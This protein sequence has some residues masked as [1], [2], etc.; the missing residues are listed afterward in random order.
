MQNC[1]VDI[2]IFIIEKK[3]NFMISSK[4]RRVKYGSGGGGGG[5]VGGGGGGGGGSCPPET[6]FAPPRPSLPSL[7][8]ALGSNY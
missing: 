3:D 8:L 7:A 6:F 2:Y 4:H 1:I 5:G